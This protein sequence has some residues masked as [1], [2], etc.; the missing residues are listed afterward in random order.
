MKHLLNIYSE[1]IFSIQFID[2]GMD[3]KKDYK[4]VL[5]TIQF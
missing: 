1:L 4:I 3:C 5:L 2:F